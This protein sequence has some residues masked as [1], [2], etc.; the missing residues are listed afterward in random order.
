VTRRVRFTLCAFA[1]RAS[2]DSIGL[3]LTPRVTAHRVTFQ[4]TDRTSGMHR[5][6]ATPCSRGCRC[7]QTKRAACEPMRACSRIRNI[8]NDGSEQNVD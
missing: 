8:G 1:A 7:R 2:S 3:Y 6:D 4:S 5:R